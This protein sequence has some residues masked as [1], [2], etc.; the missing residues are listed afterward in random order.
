MPQPMTPH[1][2]ARRAVRRAV[3]ALAAVAVAG[4]AYKNQK[5][6]EDAIRTLKHA[7]ELGPGEPAYLA[8]AEI[9]QK[10]EQPAEAARLLTQA[11]Q[12]L[13]GSGRVGSSGPEGL[14]PTPAAR[15]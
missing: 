5:K 15:S 7:I 14:S 13:P 4:L 11:A 3:T 6:N 10:S 2:P 12:A 1:T 8:L 9:Y